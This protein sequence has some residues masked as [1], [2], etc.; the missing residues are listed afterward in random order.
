MAVY[1]S[2]T[3]R[4]SRTEPSQATPNKTKPTRANP[5]QTETK[6]E[7]TQKFLFGAHMCLVALDCA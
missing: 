2:Y 3:F 7:P 5:N 6:P 1:L 4:L